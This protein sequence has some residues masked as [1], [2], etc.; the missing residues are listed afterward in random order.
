MYCSVMVCQ[1]QRRVVYYSVMVCPVPE[2]KSGQQAV[3]LL[4]RKVEQLG[5]TKTGTFTVDCE[6]YQSQARESPPS[7]GSTVN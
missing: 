1:R 4:Q 7:S 2:S 5:A 6:T 3:D